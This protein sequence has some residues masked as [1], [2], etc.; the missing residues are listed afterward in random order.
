MSPTRMQEGRRSTREEDPGVPEA[1]P[2]ILRHIRDEVG[3][4]RIDRL[5]IFPPLR[6][7]RREKGLV[8][9]SRF[10]DEGERRR[11]LTVSYQAERSGL[12]LRVEPSVSEE[13]DAPPELLPRVM[14]GVVR[15][16]GEEHADPRM[17]EV[18]GSAESFEA[19]LDELEL[20]VEGEGGLI[21]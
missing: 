5:W 14:E 4:E 13:G 9:V 18:E 11:V 3:V 10:L 8:A 19:V 17:V 12:E 15:R 1:L 7:G 21:P 20:D 16:A 2:R 6:N